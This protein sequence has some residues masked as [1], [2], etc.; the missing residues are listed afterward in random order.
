MSIYQTRKSPYWQY[1]FEIEHF[2]FYGSTKLRDERQAQ[3]F[4]EARK[5]EARALVERLKAEGSSPLTLKAACDRWWTEHGSTLADQRIR[6]VLDR[7]VEI[8]GA[9]TYLHTINDD[10]VSRMV[11]ERR[12]DT[13][14]DRTVVEND[15]KVILRRPITP[16][17]VNRTIDLLR[18]VMYRAADNWN[19]A[20]VKMPKWRKHRLKQVKRHIREISA[21]E[22]ATL[23][24]A[25]D[26]DYADVRRFAIITGLRKGNLFLTWPQVDFDLAVIRVITK[27]GQ[28]RVIPLTK[29]AYQ[30]LWRRR[31]DH[32]IHVF[33]FVAQRTWKKHPK[34]GEERIKGQRYPMTYY[35]FTTYCRKWKKH[36]VAAR[37]HDLRHTT[38]MRTLRKTRNLKVVQTLLGHTDIKTTATFYTDALVEDLREAMEEANAKVGT[39]NGPLPFGTKVTKPSDGS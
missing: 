22:E 16:R 29:E 30:M 17:T 6:S 37:I 25:E 20:I 21:A 36:G 14:R 15:R 31:G 33:T 39:L 23:D 7:L 13:R 3:T 38:G 4:E 12:K 2:R 35:G 9:R 18:Q 32:P 10:A 5:I 8:M 27:G 1:D 26:R 11:A 24:A 34:N 28:P 19:A